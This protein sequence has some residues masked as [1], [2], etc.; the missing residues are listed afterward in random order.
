MGEGMSIGNGASGRAVSIN[1]VGAGTK[2]RNCFSGDSFYTSQYKSGVPASD[3]VP[4]Y[5]RTEFA[6]GEDGHALARVR[7]LP[8]FQLREQIVRGLFDGP[9]VGGIVAAGEV[10]RASQWMLMKVADV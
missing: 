5:G 10:R 3:P 1:T 6:V 9:I 8:L 2:H 7:T 4:G